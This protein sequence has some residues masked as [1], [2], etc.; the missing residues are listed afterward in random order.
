MDALVQVVVRGTDV[1]EAHFCTPRGCT[2]KEVGLKALST[3]YLE[4]IDKMYTL[5]EKQGI[6]D[7]MIDH[8]ELVYLLEGIGEDID[9]TWGAV[10]DHKW[11]YPLIMRQIPGF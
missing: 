1:I 3:H 6:E 5:F 11:Y 4:P 7:F 8:L 9:M 10:Y 2:S